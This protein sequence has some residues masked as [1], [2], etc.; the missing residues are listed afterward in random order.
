MSSLFV[1][2]RHPEDL[3]GRRRLCLRCWNQGLGLSGHV[4][5]FHHGL[6]M[7]FFS[8]PRSLRCRFYFRATRSPDSRKTRCPT[9]V[10]PSHASSWELTPGS[11]AA[12]SPSRCLKD[13]LKAIS[14]AQGGAFKAPRSYGSFGKRGRSG[15]KTHSHRHTH[16]HTQTQKKNKNRDNMG[17]QVTGS[18]GAR[19]PECLRHLRAVAGG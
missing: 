19:G 10:G 11:G 3:R 12:G 18:Q 17:T 6:E 2:G 9:R 8:V 13:G 5:L 4:L 15:C 14:Q 7:V 1:P 16:T